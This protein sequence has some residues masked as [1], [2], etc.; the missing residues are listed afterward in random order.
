MDTD[1][2]SKQ[3]VVAIESDLNDR[4][5]MNWDLDRGTLREVKA[6][7]AELVGGILKDAIGDEL[8][9]SGEA[10]GAV[11]MN[12]Y[13]VLIDGYVTYYVAAEGVRDCVRLIEETE[14]TTC[15]DEG[16]DTASIGL[17]DPDAV[18]KKLIRSDDAPE[19]QEQVSLSVIFEETKTPGVL[20][21][22]EW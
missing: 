1:K 13:K 7:L 16:W 15:E 21:C 8:T 14:G 20:A 22:S 18:S 12:L 3:I 4:A 2:V 10:L 11:E 9:E 19:G 17:L 6:E 5:G